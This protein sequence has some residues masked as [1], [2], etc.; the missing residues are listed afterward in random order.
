MLIPFDLLKLIDDVFAPEPGEVVTLLT[1]VPHGD[2]EDRPEWGERRAM[3]EEWHA[4]FR[5][6]GM[7]RDFRVNPLIRYLATGVHAAPLPEHGDM[8]GV[9]INLQDTLFESTLVVGFGQYSATAPL[10]QLANSAADLRVA[11]LPLI[12]RR[13]EQ[14]ALSADH[15]DLQ[16]RAHTLKPLLDSAEG[17]TLVFDTGDSMYFDLRYRSALADDGYLH[18]DR[19][20]PRLINLPSGEVFS[21]TYE[22]ERPGEPSLTAGTIPVEYNGER[23][24]F[25]VQRNRIVSVE[26]NGPMGFHMRAYFADDPART[27]IAELGLG[28]NPQAVVWGNVLEDEKAGIHW[29][30]GRSDMFGGTVGVQQFRSPQSVV[31][32]DIVYAPGCPIEASTLTLHQPGGISQLIYNAGWMLP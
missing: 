15:A 11:T 26:G 31:H 17:A 25:N 19:Q 32:Q 4:A 28:I 8:S 21:A 10:M 2:V 24:V 30:Y 16:R 9:G 29:A 20:P 18:R 13:M 23:V 6:L 12:Q 22:G 5:K 27:N 14:T 1:D 7:Q 3:A